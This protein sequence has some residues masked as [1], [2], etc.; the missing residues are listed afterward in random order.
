MDELILQAL[1]RVCVQSEQ[2]IG[3]EIRACAI[4]A[5]EIGQRGFGRHIER[6]RVSRS[7]ERPDQLDAPPAVL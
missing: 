7:S 6:F 3:E 2:A 5:P 4:G 1:A